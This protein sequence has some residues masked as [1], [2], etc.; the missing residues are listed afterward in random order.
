[1]SSTIPSLMGAASDG[2][3]DAVRSL[4][5]KGAEVNET[6]QSGQTPLMRAVIGGHVNTVRLLLEAGADVRLKDRVG[7]TAIDW[8]E[9]RGFWAMA[10]ILTSAAAADPS[11]RTPEVEKQTSEQTA[12]VSQSPQIL[13]AAGA[14]TS[15][16]DN[17]TVANRQRETAPRA[18]VEEALRESAPTGATKSDRK[19]IEGLQRIMADQERRIKEIGVQRSLPESNIVVDE[20][21]DV[22]SEEA[23]ETTTGPERGEAVEA[24]ELFPAEAEFA[25]EADAHLAEEEPSQ[26]TVAPEPAAVAD[27]R[28]QVPPEAEF[29]AEAGAL[30]QPSQSIAEPDAAEVEEVRQE[31]PVEAE[32]LLGAD[33]DIPLAEPSQLIAE[34]VSAEVEGP[35]QPFVPDARIATDQNIADRAEQKTEAPERRESDIL[36]PVAHRES[37]SVPMPKTEQDLGSPTLELTASTIDKELRPPEDLRPVEAE[38]KKLKARRKSAVN[39]TSAVETPVTSPAME[40]TDTTVE[41]QPPKIQ[42]TQP[43]AAEQVRLAAIKETE[44]ANEES[45]RRAEE[46]A[47]RRFQ[48]EVVRK[49]QSEPSGNRARSS[50]QSITAVAAALKPTPK[51]SPSPTTWVRPTLWLLAGITLLGSAFVTYQLVNRSPAIETS[52]APV[53]AAPAAPTAVRQNLPVVA[54]D[55]SGKE[56][57]VPEA[58]YPPAARSEA[59]SGTVTVR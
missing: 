31:F 18:L 15:E 25:I 43:A 45:R 10:Q 32:L 22:P 49:T 33:V 30:E 23:R 40:P 2:D 50:R 9:R 55:L 1:M 52:S 14:T 47:F 54:G 29:A 4:I 5:G 27:V 19:W 39:S 34:P 51:K 26:P 56:V 37:V 24:R 7:L 3:A 59:V 12:T 36:E 6:T 53:V 21:V 41:K 57:S 16:P 38:L 17:V 20:T 35:I 46:E 8:A 13:A 42:D 11:L 58:E 48:E 28:P 44:R